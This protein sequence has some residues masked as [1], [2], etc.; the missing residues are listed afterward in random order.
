MATEKSIA[1]LPFENMSSD[2]ENEYFADGM[3]EEIINAL[4]RIEGL[5]VTAR[6]SSFVFK[7]K[8]KDIRTIGQELGVSLV[9]EG[10]VR[11]SGARVRIT[12]QLI[13]TDNG[14]HIWSENFDRSL[15]DIFVLQDEVSLLIAGKIREDFGHF[16]I[17]DQ[18]VESSTGNIGAYQL[19]LK[20]RFHHNRWNLPAFAEAASFY[21]QSI[22]EDPG[23]DLPYFGAGL[24]YSFLGSWG[25]MDRQEAFKRA[26][27]YFR[28]GLLL[29]APSHYSHYCVA[30]HLFWG[31]WN[32][33]E[34]YELL[35]KAYKINP[36]HSDTNEFMAEINT[37]LGDFPAALKHI[38]TSLSLNPLAPNH[39]YTKANIYYLQGEFEKAITILDKALTLE[40]DFVVV[41]EL[42]L[43]CQIQAGLYDGLKESIA[44]YDNLRV[45][46]LYELLY[47]LV[48]DD[49][50]VNGIEVQKMVN[51]FREAQPALLFAWDLFL[52]IHSGEQEEAMELLEEK[53][54]NKVGQIINFKHEPFL[55]PLRQ[56]EAYKALIQQ[57]FPVER[58]VAPSKKKST[59]KVLLDSEKT[60]AYTELLFS[61]M[62]EEK[63][64]LAPDLN[65][66]VLATEM[67][68][69][70]NKLS[71]L[72]NKKLQKNFSD[73][74]NSYRLKE[75]QARALDERYSHLSLLG[76]AYESGFNS[77]S[78]FNEYF[79]KATGLTPRSWVKQHSD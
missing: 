29:N 8:K 23:F 69:H 52:R 73:F 39:F 67:D 37:A 30:K 1:V 13:R 14:F 54:A 66:R 65:L 72:L 71:W 26:D 17:Q 34:A 28:Q 49:K 9:L 78:V 5:Q 77:K 36:Q 48:W 76:L 74:V 59:Q 79:R 20:G 15:T 35:L 6:T 33:R 44:R 41:I 46:G 27:D 61:K 42:K 58:L 43:A 18:L 60:K 40:P 16:D 68:L 53:V 50:E 75:F 7:N 62:E 25:A 51:Q 21:Q 55:R 10:S 64:Y 24:S 3:T 11:K 2:P 56:L 63:R 19:Y 47:R 70:P 32:Y 45:P 22:D 31:N 57:C 4:S 38:D 12:A